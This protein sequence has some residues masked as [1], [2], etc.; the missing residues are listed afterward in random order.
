V[1]GGGGGGVGVEMGRDVKEETYRLSLLPLPA[2]A[3]T[4]NRGSALNH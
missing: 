2:N 1:W 3:P 4:V